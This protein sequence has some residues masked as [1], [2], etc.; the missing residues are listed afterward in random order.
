MIS[1]GG[2]A[3][4]V[5]KSCGFD[6]IWQR[7]K[8]EAV[9]TAAL[10]PALEAYRDLRTQLDAFTAIISDALLTER[11][12]GAGAVLT[13]SQSPSLPRNKIHTKGETE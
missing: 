13:H 12:K 9:H 10:R 4:H 11:L 7:S 8:D 6:V 5:I 2:T 3:A 1:D